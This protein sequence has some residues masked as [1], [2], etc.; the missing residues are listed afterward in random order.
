[1]NNSSGSYL[2]IIPEIRLSDLIDTDNVRSMM[3]S[4]YSF[5]G[6]PMS[7]VD[8]NGNIL[9]G[10]GWQV[11]C[12]KFHRVNSATSE[13][14][15]ESDLRL[16]EEIPEGEFRLY[17]CKNGMWDMATPLFFGPHKIGYLFSGQFFFKD[18]EPDTG[19]F[20]DQ[21]A[22]F[23]FDAEEYIEALK[24]VPRV[25]RSY[26]EKSEIFFIKLANTLANLGYG[27]LKLEKALDDTQVLLKNLSHHKFLLEEAQ[28]IA[29]LGSWELDL[30]KQRLTWSDEV[31]RIF[32]IDPHEF[33]PSFE[34]FLALV[35]PDDRES[36][37]M[38]YSGSVS[39]GLDTYEIKHRIIRENGEVRWLHEKCRHF[40]ERDGKIVRS[41]GMVHDITER[42]NSEAALIK[43]KEKLIWARRM[44]RRKIIAINKKHQFMTFKK[45]TVLKS[46]SNP[47]HKIVRMID[48]RF[49]YPSYKQNT[50]S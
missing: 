47:A 16:T 37:A 2:T 29:H 33:I 7:L 17:K 22:K 21:A 1:M 28:S 19:F 50:S 5:T 24:E 4:F 11:I 9:A 48:S 18:E 43:S 26:I 14:C 12:T 45:P 32:G 39:A 36:V 46:C 35:H 44:H 13:N 6:I 30:L 10:A 25:E 3:E 20:I 40:K 27:R 41:V 8:H 42:K 31:Y 38:S 15:K 34:G 23:G 49:S